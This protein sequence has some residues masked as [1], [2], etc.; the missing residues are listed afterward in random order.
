VQGQRKKRRASDKN[1]DQNQVNALLSPFIV[2][3]FPPGN[4][5]CTYSPTTP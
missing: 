2:D 3:S 4:H 5:Y 1:K